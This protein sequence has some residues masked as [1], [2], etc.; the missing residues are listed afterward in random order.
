[1]IQI[2][3]QHSFGLP[4][5][6]AAVYL[7]KKI[8]LK[9]LE[10]SGHIELRKDLKSSYKLVYIGNIEWPKVDTYFSKQE[11]AYKNTIFNF[12]RWDILLQAK[13]LKLESLALRKFPGETTN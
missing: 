12:K 10:T 7:A 2:K 13:I 6:S 8:L 1:M 3:K 9:L 4:Y 11:K 5:R